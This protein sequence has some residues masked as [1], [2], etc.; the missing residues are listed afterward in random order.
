MMLFLCDVFGMLCCMDVIVLC[1]V[2]IFIIWKYGLVV[3]LKVYLCFG[4]VCW[5]WDVR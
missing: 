1:G 3:C 5:V 2:V 4:F